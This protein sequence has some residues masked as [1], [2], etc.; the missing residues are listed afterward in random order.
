MAS[1]N[2]VLLMGN[3]TRDPELTY[4]PS[5][6]AICKFA[7]AVSRKYR[8]KTGEERE[9][10]AFI[11]CTAFD[12]RGEII[13][14]YFT[15]GKPIFVEGSLKMDTWDDKTTGQKRSK[16]Y[17]IVDGFQFV[18]GRDGAPGGGGGGGGGYAGEDEGSGP[19]APRAPAGRGPGRPGGPPQGGRPAPQ[20]PAP[21]Q[22]FPDENQFKEDDIPF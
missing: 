14:Q 13:N 15:K 22:P 10:V 8:T 9:D 5:Q 1:Y 2:K 4:T 11:D 17:V 3:L 6:V 12:K 21:E 18:G 7:V 19:P 20:R 16:L